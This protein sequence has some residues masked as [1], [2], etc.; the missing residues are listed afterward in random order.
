MSVPLKIGLWNFPVL[1]LLE[2]SALDEVTNLRS[3]K[4]ELYNYGARSCRVES[5]SQSDR[6]L[7]FSCDSEDCKQML[8]RV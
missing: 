1:D 6:F 7:T 3:F 5:L 4:V 2:V 8:V